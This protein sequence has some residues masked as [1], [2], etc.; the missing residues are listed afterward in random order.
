MSPEQQQAASQHN[1]MAS[2]ILAGQQA[3]RAQEVQ[4]KLNAIYEQNLEILAL[5]KKAPKIKE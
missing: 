1:A 3:T 2:A 5:L 4:E